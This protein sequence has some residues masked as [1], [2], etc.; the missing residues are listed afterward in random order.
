[1]RE[2]WVRLEA[3]EEATMDTPN[4]REELEEAGLIDLATGEPTTVGAMLSDGFK[5]L[6]LEDPRALTSGRLEEVGRKIREVGGSIV[7]ANITLSS[8]G[9][10][11]LVAMAA[12][13]GTPI[14]LSENPTAADMA[15]MGE[16]LE[17]IAREEGKRQT[18]MDLEAAKAALGWRKKGN[19]GRFDKAVERRRAK[20]KAARR[21]AKR[22]G[23]GRR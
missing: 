12:A 21:A 20:G 4:T 16:L 8:A 11:R 7:P 9:L 5:D 3:A 17:T 1:V 10:A 22:G 2:H 6:G 18:Q 23:K 14:A 15:K 13:R 19:K